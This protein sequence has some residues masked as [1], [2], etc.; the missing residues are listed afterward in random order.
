M[1]K[2]HLISKHSYIWAA[3]ISIF[4]G[5]YTYGLLFVPKGCENS[6]CIPYKESTEDDIVSLDQ[7]ELV[8]RN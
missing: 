1:T 2:V 4:F 8:V 6:L 3:K 7:T 5:K